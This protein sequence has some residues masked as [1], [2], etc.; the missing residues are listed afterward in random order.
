MIRTMYILVHFSSSQSLPSF[1]SSL[2][3]DFFNYFV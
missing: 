1:L 2:S 3:F